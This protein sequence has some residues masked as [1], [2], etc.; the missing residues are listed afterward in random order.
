MFVTDI[1]QDGWKGGHWRR[2]KRLW[3]H[4]NSPKRAVAGASAI[5]RGKEDATFILKEYSGLGTDEMLVGNCSA[6]GQGWVSYKAKNF[7]NSSKKVNLE[8]IWD[9]RKRKNSRLPDSEQRNGEGNNR[10]TRKI[11]NKELLQIC[12]KN[13]CARRKT[14]H[15]YRQENYKIKIKNGQE[16]RKKCP[17]ELKRKHK[18]KYEIS[19]FV[20][21][22]G[23]KKTNKDWWG[24]HLVVYPTAFFLAS[25]T[26]DLLSYPDSSDWLHFSRSQSHPIPVRK[27]LD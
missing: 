1:L 19:H 2:G 16:I 23:Q 6:L 20:S 8:S 17:T 4:G 3:D 18:Q 7:G 10:I 14:G 15:G 27:N 26:L 12:K 25:R 5:G 11:I 24:R 9:W 13:E 21:K 22:I